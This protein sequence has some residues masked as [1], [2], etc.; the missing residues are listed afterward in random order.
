M[1]GRR[2]YFDWIRSRRPGQ[3][4]NLGTVPRLRLPRREYRRGWVGGPSTNGVQQYE[5]QRAL[6]SKS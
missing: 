2:V 1:P 4:P 6:N 3:G 5:A